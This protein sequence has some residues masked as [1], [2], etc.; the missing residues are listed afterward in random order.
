MKITAEKLISVLNNKARRIIASFKF[1]PKA[2]S[3]DE[4]LKIADENMELIVGHDESSSQFRACYR[5]IRNFYSY[6]WAVNRVKNLG[7]VDHLKEYKV[8][9]SY[10]NETVKEETSVWI[11][12]ELGSKE[13]YGE[14]LLDAELIVSYIQMKVLAGEDI[15]LLQDLQL[16]IIN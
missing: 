7:R 3:Y 2:F 6:A 4:A 1:A 13:I 12:K 16:T 10:N 5:N 15:D 14:D 8:K 11:S 9:T